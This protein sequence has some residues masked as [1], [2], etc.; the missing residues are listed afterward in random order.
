MEP[1]EASDS[2]YYGA[3]LA[4]IAVGTAPENYRS[5]PEIQ[6]QINS[7][8]EYLNHTFTARS[9]INSV[10]LLWAST[11]LPG[12][13]DTERQ[14]H[15]IHEVMNQQDSDGGWGLSSTAWPSR[16][17]LHSIVRRRLRSDWTRQDTNSDGFATG[18]I[19]FVLEQTGVSAE[20]PR[21][22]RGVAWLESHQN[23]EDGAWPSTSLTKRRNP[24]SNTGH[25]M[26]DAAT[27]YAV[28]ALTENG[29]AMKNTSAAQHQTD[30]TTA[31]GSIVDATRER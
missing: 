12:L 10:M 27:A 19:I 9:T 31:T 2:K 5:R 23:R 14:T 25:F 29:M 22:K 15:I 11:K 8:R 3:A 6:A 28:L 20:D 16:W 4:A 17:S 26:R 13:I 18:L 1:W 7:L 24:D 21:L 30:Q